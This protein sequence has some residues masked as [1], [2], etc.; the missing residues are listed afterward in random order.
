MKV[1]ILFLLFC[2]VP[3]TLS[4]GKIQRWIDADGRLHFG[5]VPPSSAAAERV[6]LEVT[7]ADPDNPRGMLSGSSTTPEEWRASRR[8]R[9]SEVHRKPRR[10]YSER[11]R[12]RNAAVSGRILVGMQ[13][14]EVRRA[15]GEPTRIRRRGTEGLLRESWVYIDDSGQ[16]SVNLSN[17]KVSSFRQ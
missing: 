17:G 16:R 12:Y 1:L 7:P 4:A 15:W 6:E 2:S 14:D 9:G 13:A 3:F 11:L 10:S 8:A 5:D